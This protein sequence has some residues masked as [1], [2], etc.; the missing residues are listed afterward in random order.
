MYI[1]KYRTKCGFWAKIKK[2]LWRNVGKLPYGCEF[3]DMGQ[4]G[5]WMQGGNK[6]EMRKWLI[7][8]YPDRSWNML[9]VGKEGKYVVWSFEAWEGEDENR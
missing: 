7:K 5:F 4:L 1:M 8:Y 6:K 3:A 9:K 2:F